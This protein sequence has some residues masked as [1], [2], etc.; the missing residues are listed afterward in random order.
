MVLTCF[1]LSLAFQDFQDQG[2]RLSHPRWSVD[3]LKKEDNSAN[4]IIE[5]RV[6]MKK[7]INNIFATEKHLQQNP[8]PG[9]PSCHLGSLPECPADSLKHKK[10][11]MFKISNIMSSVLSRKSKPK[12]KNVLFKYTYISSYAPTTGLSSNKSCSEGFTPSSF[13]N[14]AS[15]KGRW[16]MQPLYKANPHRTPNWKYLRS[17]CVT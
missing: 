6:H 11:I 15:G 17:S 8:F 4:M 13:L 12:T 9:F 14:R 16:M 5:F 10:R 1:D 2:R 7:R 3:Q